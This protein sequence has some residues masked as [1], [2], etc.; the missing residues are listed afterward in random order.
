MEYIKICRG[1]ACPRPLARCKS[2]KIKDFI[3]RVHPS[4]PG[5]GKSRAYGSCKKLLSL[6]PYIIEDNPVQDTCC[7]IRLRF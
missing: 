4:I 6:P 5:M 7:S 2:I 1:G 3:V